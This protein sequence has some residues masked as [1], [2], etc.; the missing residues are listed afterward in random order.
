MKLAFRQVTIALAV[1]AAGVVATSAV[2]YVDSQHALS[3]VLRNCTVT[4]A[5][6]GSSEPLIGW[7]LSVT[8]MLA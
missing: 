7:P 8:A 4:G 1:A 5:V 6:R 3:R 2:V